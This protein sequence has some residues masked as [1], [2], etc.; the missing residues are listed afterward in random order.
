M[1]SIAAYVIAETLRGFVQDSLR[2]H[3]GR[4]L[5]QIFGAGVEAAVRGLAVLFIYWLILLWMYR[6]K[7]FLRI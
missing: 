2:I 6:R 5:F 4:A 7:L 1:N 3:L